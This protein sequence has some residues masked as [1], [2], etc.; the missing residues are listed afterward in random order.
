MIKR[1]ELNL[2]ELCNLKCGF[3]PRST[4]YPNQNLNMDLATVNL[5]ANQVS[6]LENFQCVV[7]CGRGEPTLH[8][9]FSEVVEILV[10]KN[11]NVFLYTNGARFDQHYNAISKLG[12]IH[13]DVYSEDDG[14]FTEAVVK[15]KSLPVTH[16]VVMMKPEDGKIRHKWSN[17]KFKLN[18]N[19]DFVENRAGS[20]DLDIKLKNKRYCKFIE[21]LVFIDWNGDYNL[22]CQDWKPKALSNIY[23]EDIFTYFNKN[24]DLQ[25][26][27]NG[28]RSGN[29]LSPCDVCSI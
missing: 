26:Y 1:V 4:F 7:L 10:E 5:V 3:C 2:T 6:E 17:G 22:C 13:Y 14:D 11:I 23:N 21:E 27:K 19:Q 9:N 15:V 28:I 12:V 20:M 29:R 18:S 8:P 25:S 24:K 16:K